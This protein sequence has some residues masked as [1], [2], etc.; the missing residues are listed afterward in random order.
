MLY[1]D[2]CSAVNSCEGL[3]SDVA[4]WSL[5]KAAN[6]QRAAG[7]FAQ[8]LE[9][10]STC[11]AGL[12]C[13]TG[14]AVCPG[15]R[16]PPEGSQLGAPP[17]VCAEAPA[18]AVTSP[19][20]KNGQHC[21]SPIEHYG[22]SFC[23]Q[24]TASM[25]MHEP[26]ET[27]VTAGL[28]FKTLEESCGGIYHQMGNTSRYKACRFDAN[29][30]RCAR[31]GPKDV[32]DGPPEPVCGPA[33]GFGRIGLTPTWS[34]ATT[35]PALPAPTP[36][37]TPVAV[38]M[39]PPPAPLPR[40]SD[41][42]PDIDW[43][44]EETAEAAIGAGGFPKGASQQQQ[45]AK[46]S[47]QQQQRRQQQQQQQQAR[48]AQRASTS[49]SKWDWRMDQNFDWRMDVGSAS[50]LQ[51]EEQEE[52]GGD[53]DGEDED[54]SSPLHAVG[55][56]H[57][58]ASTPGDGTS[59]YE[60]ARAAGQ[61]VPEYQSQQEYDRSNLIH[62]G[63]NGITPAEG[64]TVCMCDT[65]GQGADKNG[66]TCMTGARLN[67]SRVCADTEECHSELPARYGQWAKLCRTLPAAAAAPPV[68]SQ[69][70]AAT[71]ATGLK[72]AAV[73]NVCGP[74]TSVGP[75]KPPAQLGKVENLCGPDSS[76]GPCAD[77]APPAA[78]TNDPRSRYG[79]WSLVPDRPDEVATSLRFS[80]DDTDPSAACDAEGH[81]PHG[82][83]HFDEPA[84]A[85]ATWSFELSKPQQVSPHPNPHLS[86]SPSPFTLT[87]HPHPHPQPSP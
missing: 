38:M 20:P 59:E 67:E 69:H 13:A 33:C 52:E 7:K 44:D 5:S 53:E 66:L 39:P 35:A 27:E 82:R 10:G 55:I 81:G 72:A 70:A 73:D 76:V 6:P 15:G 71:V 8:F 24:L 56:G 75:C 45:Q 68:P 26:L 54:G 1:K 42:A 2:A 51:L 30:G 28:S 50:L 11:Y 63:E 48:N 12:P 36:V 18:S 23:Y 85:T 86:P 21:Y 78:A 14:A 25:V 65:P 61:K 49:A 40:G 57:D 4:Q 79:A 41:D 58:E 62:L 43:S 77:A 84:T 3:V 19:A 64:E 37:A 74:G 80:F 46:A 34:F 83:D 29:K 47:Q 9:A 32:F 17:P 31:G 22:V 87:F 16:V 60:L